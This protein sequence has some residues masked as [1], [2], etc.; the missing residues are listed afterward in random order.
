MKGEAVLGID[1]QTLW[2][3]HILSAARN[4]LIRPLTVELRRQRV[5]R[6]PGQTAHQKQQ[7][8]G[9]LV[10]GSIHIIEAIGPDVI[11]FVQ[12]AWKRSLLKQD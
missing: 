4:N 8:Q 6:V 7:F 1:R 3:I 10:K 11:M 9:I 2:P 5:R 12:H